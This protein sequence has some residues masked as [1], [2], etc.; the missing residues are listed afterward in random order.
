LDKLAAELKKGDQK[1]TG[2]LTGLW[3]MVYGA[4]KAVPAAVGAIAALDKL[5]DLLGF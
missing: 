4:V 2:V 1:N 5:K 3:N